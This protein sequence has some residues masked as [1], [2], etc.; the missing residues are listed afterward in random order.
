MSMHVESQ[1]SAATTQSHMALVISATQS[2][3]QL[4]SSSSS[5]TISPQTEVS[6]MDSSKK[7]RPP[8]ESSESEVL[9]DGPLVLPMESSTWIV[10]I[11]E[12]Q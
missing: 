11:E 12:S 2:C 6:P 5:Q 9:S 7:S 8:K 1:A 4:V 3:G 10:P